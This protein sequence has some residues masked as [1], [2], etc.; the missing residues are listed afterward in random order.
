MTKNIINFKK[1]EFIEFLNLNNT[2]QK[3]L[4]LLLS[5][6][7][8]K[9]KYFKNYLNEHKIY[10]LL[11]FEQIVKASI[12]KNPIN[13]Q[14]IGIAKI[15]DKKLW[16]KDLNPYVQFFGEFEPQLDKLVWF[17]NS[18]YEH[19]KEVLQKRV[20]ISFVEDTIQNNQT[21]LKEKFATSLFWIDEDGQIT[22]T[23]AYF[24]D[25][26]DIKKLLDKFEKQHDILHQK[27]EDIAQ[28]YADNLST[29]I[30]NSE[31][32]EFV[33]KI[34]K[35][36]N[37]KHNFEIVKQVAEFNSTAYSNIRDLEIAEEFIDNNDKYIGTGINWEEKINE[38]LEQYAWKGVQNSVFVKIANDVYD[39]TE[40]DEFYEL[41]D[42]MN[43]KCVPKEEMYER[44]I[45]Y[46]VKSLK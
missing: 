1:Q 18:P 41:D 6:D 30:N 44:I 21:Q 11:D 45:N 15:L 46:W 5:K 14:F 35:V 29:I 34:L 3:E 33:Y 2:N 7:F 20:F 9:S 32:N 24:L 27:S 4:E 19:S 36:L 39:K 16:Y 25:N 31:S 28:E 10:K 22:L 26:I 13:S 12:S 23:K 37:T 40:D 38:D 42:S 17:N 8:E 43:L